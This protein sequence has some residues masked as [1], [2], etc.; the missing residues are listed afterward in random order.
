MTDPYIQIRDIWVVNRPEHVGA[1]QLG[2]H[3]S[4]V[5]GV[6]PQAKMFT[7]VPLTSKTTAAR[8]P[9]TYGIP[10]SEANKLNQESVALVFQTM[11]VPY[12]HIIGEN[13]I[14]KLEQNH[15]VTICAM[16]KR[17]FNL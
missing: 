12:D 17:Y 9:N 1:V 7:I 11:C 10:I 4:I 2:P 3:P 5:V 6:C 15:Y 16:L 8:F 14:G 13:K